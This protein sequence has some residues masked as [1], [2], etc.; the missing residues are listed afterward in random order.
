MG[1]T[2]EH[3]IEKACRELIETALV[4][5]ESNPTVYPFTAWPDDSDG[6]NIS[7]PAI[8]IR[9]SPFMPEGPGSNLG[10]VEAMLVVADKYDNDRTRATLERIWEAS[11]AVMTASGIGNKVET[12][13]CV[14]GIDDSEAGILAEDEETRKAQK[15][16]SY[17]VQ[18]A[19]VA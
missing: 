15:E 7:M 16:R 10:M 11:T 13:W 17:A 19:I 3:A 12:P 14:F 2:A 6:E 8:S 5:D 18:V 1:M 9:C 4:S